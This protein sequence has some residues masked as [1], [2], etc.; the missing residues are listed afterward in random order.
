M[1]M[2]PHQL[3]DTKLRASNVSFSQLAPETAGKLFNVLLNDL[4]AQ[5]TLIDLHSVSFL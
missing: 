5:S 3:P 4:T 1:V 2:E